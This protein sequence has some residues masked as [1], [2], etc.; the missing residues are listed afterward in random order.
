MQGKDRAKVKEVAVKL[1]LEGKY[2]AKPYIEQ[3]LLENLTK[4]VQ[5]RLL[6]SARLHS[7]DLT[8]GVQVR[9]LYSA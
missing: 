5:V 7:T 8:K 6:Y 1:G 2:I 4:E 9:L 3:I